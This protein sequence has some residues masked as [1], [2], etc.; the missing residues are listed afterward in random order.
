M[1]S[2]LQLARRRKLGALRLVRE[3]S[4]DAPQDY[5]RATF[6]C[7][8]PRTV[9]Q[10]MEPYAQREETEVFWILALDSQHQVIWNR[11]LTVTRGILNSSLVHPREVFR[12]AIHANAYAVIA[13]HNHP[14]GDPN[15]SPDDKAI[16]AQLVAAGRL[17]DISM[18][19]HVIIGCGRYISFAESGLL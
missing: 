16:T 17:L 4:F 14:S 12:L 13:V 11:P 15:P 19:D 6:R 9:F 10:F 18:A 3:D 2:H 1:T 8:C 5:P 7:D